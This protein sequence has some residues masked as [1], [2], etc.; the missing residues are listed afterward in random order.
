MVLN[1]S[2]TQE[3]IDKGT[4]GNY[5]QCPIAL[6]IQRL[7]VLTCPAVTRFGMYHDIDDRRKYV[8]LPPGAI[9][10]IEKFDAKLPVE[11]FDFTLE[12]DIGEPKQKKDEKTAGENAAP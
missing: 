11:P 12:V 3:D 7:G 9:S 5:C 6:A 1:V 10:F 8:L 2:V 4:P